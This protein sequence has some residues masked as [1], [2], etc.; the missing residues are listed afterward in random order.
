[1]SNS[2]TSLICS[3]FDWT[4]NIWYNHLAIAYMHTCV[5]SMFCIRLFGNAMAFHGWSRGTATLSVELT[6][7][8][9]VSRKK[10]HTSHYFLLHL[11]IFSLWLDYG[12]RNARHVSHRHS[13]VKKKCNICRMHIKHRFDGNGSNVDSPFSVGMEKYHVNEYGF[14][15]L[16]GIAT[17][18][19]ENQSSIRSAQMLRDVATHIPDVRAQCKTVGGHSLID[20]WI[21]YTFI[22]RTICFRLIANLRLAE[23]P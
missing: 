7:R 5:D 20:M 21:M 14:Q 12:S 22:T 16:N 2:F 17:F 9:T 3:L 10:I 15:S 23:N 11:I 4:N 19:C 13:Q 1:M 18:R 6:Y 8:L